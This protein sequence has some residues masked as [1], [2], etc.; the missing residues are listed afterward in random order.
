MPQKTLQEIINKVAVLVLNQEEASI[1]TKFSYHQEK[2]IFKKL[3]D[4]CPGIVIMTKG[5]EGAVVSVGKHIFEAKSPAIKVKD[6]T[7]AGDAFGS[8]FVTGFIQS[9]GNIEEALQLGFA[10]GLSCITQW[11]AKAG[12]LKKGD[13]FQRVAIKKE[14]CSD[15]KCK[16]K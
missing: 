5:P 8:G 11:G 10:N 14:A 4:I 6:R 15:G 16:V 9:K 12:L 3:D 2:E 7:G 1:L 13:I